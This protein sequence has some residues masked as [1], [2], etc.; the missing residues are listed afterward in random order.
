M[1]GSLPDT[2]DILDLVIAAQWPRAGMPAKRHRLGHKIH[3]YS[4]PHSTETDPRIWRSRCGLYLWR[5]D[6]DGVTPYCFMRH[7]E[8][9]WND[10][11]GRGADYNIAYPTANGAVGTL[12]L[13]GLREA[14]DDVRYATLLMQRIEAARQHGA[15]AA[16]A[17]AEETFQWIEQQDFL[18]ADLDVVRAKMVAYIS[19]LAGE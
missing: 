5:L 4:L 1:Y 7:S 12:A 16:K 19:K 14:A 3:S 10:L 6:Y 11:D 8:G 17:V 2:P 18:A 9:V 13:A 15:P